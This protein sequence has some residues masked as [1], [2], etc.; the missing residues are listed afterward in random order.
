MEEE[1]AV[2]YLGFNSQFRNHRCPKDL[3]LGN[4]GVGEGRQWQAVFRTPERPIDS[5]SNMV[6]AEGIFR[7]V[8]Q[9]AVEL[10]AVPS[11]FSTGVSW[12]VTRTPAMELVAPGAEPVTWKGA[13]HDSLDG[14]ALLEA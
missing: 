12:S 14:P 4:L 11:L 10:G 3:G 7:P 13:L 1:A 2:D 8:V 5:K 9:V 6:V